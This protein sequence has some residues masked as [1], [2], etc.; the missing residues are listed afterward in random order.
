MPDQESLATNENHPTP[1]SGHSMS[2]FWVVNLIIFTILAFFII[3]ALAVQSTHTIKPP[4]P[5]PHPP[6]ISSTPVSNTPSGSVV[7]YWKLDEGRTTN[8]RDSSRFNNHGKVVSAE[9]IS[10][11]GID[12]LDSDGLTSYVRV[13]STKN[14]TFTSENFTL[15]A[16][17]YPTSEADQIKRGIVSTMGFGSPGY[18]LAYRKNT[19]NNLYL[20]T[21]DGMHNP[22]AYSIGSVITN[23]WNY[24]ALVRESGKYTF[25]IN[26]L[27]DSVI[28][29]TAFDIQNSS[30]LL[31]GAT[32]A[33]QYPDP[34]GGYFSGKIREVTIYNTALTAKDIQKEYQRAS[35]A[36][37]RPAAKTSTNQVKEVSALGTYCL[38][39]EKP[40]C[41]LPVAE[42]NFDTSGGNTVYDSSGHANHGTISGGI[43]W[44]ARED[45]VSGS[46][47]YLDGN[48]ASYVAFPDSP[49]LRFQDELTF[50]AWIK[51]TT[52]KQAFILDKWASGKEDTQISI[53][54]TPGKLTFYLYGPFDESGL[55]STQKIPQNE[56]THV[57]TVY[58]GTT[59]SVYI[60]GQ[61]DA[62]HSVSKPLRNANGTLYLGL[63]PDRADLLSMGY[64]GY[65]DDV[66]L[67][68]Y[69]RSPTQIRRDYQMG[70]TFEAQ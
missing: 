44:K 6:L 13:P 12:A 3:G 57:A 17:I 2:R 39:G 51:P 56:W 27:P 45:C 28:A 68:S 55:N 48:T 38:P 14:Y 20:E 60:N 47:L 11:S 41:Q 64:R 24:V 49:T 66:H 7:G 69:A 32:E 23:T 70:K 63:N 26:A 8:V 30:D 53:G 16:W 61:L 18:L 40:A 4:V 34:G 36:I 67:F 58:D 43:V 46:C 35:A 10:G 9:W 59:A 65:I 33:S 62:V 42:W 5:L 22:N 50:E 29:D 54:A 52:L 15:S 21:F 1:P 37:L 19:G 31:I 25:Y